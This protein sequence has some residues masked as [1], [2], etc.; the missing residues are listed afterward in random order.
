[1]L[2]KKYSN[3]E[4]EIEPTSYIDNK[5]KVWF[6]G[7]DVVKILGYSDTK[8]AIKKHVD[9]ED[10]L[11]HFLSVEGVETFLQPPPPQTG[12]VLPTPQRRSNL[13]S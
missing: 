7:K 2:E 12:G 4:L 6:K 3:D 9:N 10:K 13:G 1:M 5:Q 11:L 8:Q